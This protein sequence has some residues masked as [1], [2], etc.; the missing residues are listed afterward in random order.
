MSGKRGAAHRA[1]GIPT[2]LRE[3]RRTG[4]ALPEFHNRIT[5]FKVTFPR[6]ALLTPETTNWINSLNAGN[7]SATQQMALAQ[8][9]DGRAI[10]NQSMRNLGLDSRRATTELADLVSRNLAVRIGERRHARYVL[11]PPG[12]QPTTATKEPQNT[13]VAADRA[14]AILDAL[15]PGAEL[16]RRD[17]EKA[18]N[19]NQMT[20][21]RTLDTLIATGKIEATAPPKSPLRRYRRTTGS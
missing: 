19:I 4:S 3:L 15:P 1:S 8:M 2:M 20:V 21:L 12:S 11:T 10:T 18:T 14:A 13:D 5:R 7:L 16:S 6:H 17:I 9:R